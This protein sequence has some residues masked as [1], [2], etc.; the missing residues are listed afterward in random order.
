MYKIATANENLPLVMDFIRKRHL[1]ESL[2]IYLHDLDLTCD[3]SGS[4]EKDEVIEYL[5]DHYDFRMAGSPGD[6]GQRTI[7][8]NDNT[9]GRN[10][11]SWIEDVSYVYLLCSIISKLITTYV[12][13][14]HK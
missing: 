7:I 1:Y 10:C 13:Y 12:V 5:I 11:M 6:T 3:N 4:F 14:V 8:D 9:V 2:G